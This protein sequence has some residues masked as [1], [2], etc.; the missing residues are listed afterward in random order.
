MSA[1]DVE[2]PLEPAFSE[3]VAQ[4][5]LSIHFDNAELIPRLLEFCSNEMPMSEH[6]LLLDNTD[7]VV[8][9]RFSRD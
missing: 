8:R 1:V 5:T 9:V 7:L 3:E 6:Q 4:N 2:T